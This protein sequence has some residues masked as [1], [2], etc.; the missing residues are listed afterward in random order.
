MQDVD[1]GDAIICALS[2]HIGRLTGI[3][4]PLGE[5]NRFET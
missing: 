3:S 5:I 2:M 4:R 1:L